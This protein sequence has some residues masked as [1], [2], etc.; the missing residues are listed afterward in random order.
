MLEVGNTYTNTERQQVTIVSIIEDSTG[1]KVYVG[2]NK[3]IYHANGELVGFP[4]VYDAL[5]PV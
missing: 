5:Q 2:S 3:Y 1:E 4:G